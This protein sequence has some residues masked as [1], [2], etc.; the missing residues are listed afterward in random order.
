MIFTASSLSQKRA[1]PAIPGDAEILHIPIFLMLLQHEKMGSS[2]HPSP[3]KALH[4]VPPGRGD[5][6]SN[7]HE[8][9]RC[10]AYVT[11]DEPPT[12]PI[13]Y[14]RKRAERRCKL[15]NENHARTRTTEN[16]RTADTAL[17]CCSC[18]ESTRQSRRVKVGRKRMESLL[19]CRGE[20]KMGRYSRAMAVMEHGLVSS[21]VAMCPTCQP[22]ETFHVVVVVV[23]GRTTPKLVEFRRC[24]WERSGDL[25]RRQV[26]RTGMDAQLHGRAVRS[27]S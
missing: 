3:P 17:L 25:L 5:A 15:Q 8:A 9:G 18:A 21:E 26:L 12:W 23:V 7:L 22:E 6:N 4:L 27:N 16:E 20:Y 14:R 1:C 19:Q 2:K 11:P 24:C 10:T 13:E